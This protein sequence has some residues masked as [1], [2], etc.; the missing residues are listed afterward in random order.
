MIGSQF[1]ASVVIVGAGI[2][3]MLSAWYLAKE[4]MQITLLEQNEPGRESSWAG[5]G[6]ISPLYPWRYVEAVTR[7]A[8]WSQRHYAEL[9]RQLEVSEV[10]LE[11]MLA[12]LERM[13]H[14]RQ[15]SGGGCAGHCQGCAMAGACAVGGSGRVWALTEKGARASQPHEQA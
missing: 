4:G 5:G 2:S 8:Q 6:I 9:A 1:V 10:L 7:L 11:G 15:I 3:G 12:D 14:L 13:G